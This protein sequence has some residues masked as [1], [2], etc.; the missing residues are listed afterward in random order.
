MTKEREKQILANPST[1]N[2]VHDVIDLTQDKDCID[3]YYDIL[4][5]AEILKARMDRVLGNND[6]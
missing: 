2:L 6:N 4:L 3:A 1:H 5:A